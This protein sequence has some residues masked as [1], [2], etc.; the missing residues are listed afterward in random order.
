MDWVKA[1]LLIIRADRRN[2]DVMRLYMKTVRR[3]CKHIVRVGAV[4]RKKRVCVAGV[5]ALTALEGKS[6]RQRLE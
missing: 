4:A 2:S 6:E 3:S 1:S 5:T